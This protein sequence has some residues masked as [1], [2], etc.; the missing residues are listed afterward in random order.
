MIIS[1]LKNLVIGKI[2]REF[3]QI[4]KNTV[5]TGP[6]KAKSVNG[7]SLVAE[8]GFEPTTSGL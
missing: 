4:K 1:C 7:L 8:I 3:S 6:E 2:Y 5:N